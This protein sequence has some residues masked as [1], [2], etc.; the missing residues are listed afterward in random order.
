MKDYTVDYL[1]SRTKDR[2]SELDKKITKETYTSNKKRLE[3]LK[4]TNETLLS[5]L[6]SLVDNRFKQ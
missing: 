3:E 1:I 4:E 5:T 2:I 6:F